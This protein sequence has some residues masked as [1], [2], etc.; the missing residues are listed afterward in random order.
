MDV[1]SCWFPTLLILLVINIM[2]P[3]RLLAKELQRGSGWI[4][5]VRYEKA[6]CKLERN[7]LRID[8]LTKCKH[9]E[10]I[11][12]FLKFRI[13]NNGCF[14]EKSVR[15]FQLKL[16]AKEIVNAKGHKHVLEEQLTERIQVL[17]SVIH[18]KLLPSVVVYVRA[19]KH[20]TRKAQRLTHNSK[21]ARLSEE[22]QRPLFRVGN[23]VNLHQLD[24]TPP[25]YVLDTLS[26]GPKNPV[27]DRFNPK[28]ILAEIDI[29]LA[30]C[31]RNNVS[32][33]TMTDINLRT[34]N[35]IKKC[36][37]LKSSRNVA[38]TSKYLK[39]NDL[40]AVPFDKGV[41]ICIMKRNMYNEK[42]N[43]ILQIPQFEK[44]R[45]PRK[46]AQHPVLKEQERVVGVLKELRDAGNIEVSLY[47]KPEEASQLDCT[48][49]QKF[50]KPAS[51][52]DLYYQC[53]AH[54]TS[55]LQNK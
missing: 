20:E 28:H 2:L 54:V 51:Q 47:Q 53:Q 49:L 14:D 7:N 4:E 16:L 38:M 34:L 24:S 9:S 19:A 33:K 32:Q 41:G 35:Y 18:E 22:Q 10:I 13:P 6:S 45:K 26:L 15:N 23:T 39:E 50:I 11:P 29:L 12:R 3:Y 44:Y 42:L 5:Y 21:L 1:F 55:K 8:F 30:H 37:K 25:Q 36:S 40:V 46:N 43:A 27:L 17:R 52:L 31:K 48:A